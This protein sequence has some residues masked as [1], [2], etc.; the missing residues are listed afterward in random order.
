[1]QSWRIPHPP[2]YG[3]RL[4]GRRGGGGI[5]IPRCSDPSFGRPT[6]RAC[7][8]IC[9]FASMCV[10][11]VWG[12]A[13]CVC[14]WLAQSGT[15]L[16]LWALRVPK[17]RRRDSLVPKSSFQIS[18]S[19]FFLFRVL[20]GRYHFVFWGGRERMEKAP[21]PKICC[22]IRKNGKRGVEMVPLT[23]R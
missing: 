22:Y 1:M 7:V 21:V 20:F 10:C 13:M 2:V 18:I 14:V 6:V 9:C 3:T 5:F 16:G 17:R 11:A 15:S 12:N 8:C 19:S 23:S 4:S